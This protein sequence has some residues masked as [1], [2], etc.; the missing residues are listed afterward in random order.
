MRQVMRHLL[1]SIPL[2]VGLASGV[3]SDE[4]AYDARAAGRFVEQYCLDCHGADDP[5]AGL[6]LAGF[7]GGQSLTDGRPKWQKIVRR[8]RQHEMPPSDVEQPPLEER[9]AFAQWVAT[10]LHEQ[11]CGDG[12]WRGPAPIRRLNKSEYRATIRDLLGVHF[13]A[14]FALP[15]DGAGGEGFD[16]AAETLFLSPLHT[17]MYLEAAKQA[18]AYAANDNRAQQ[19]IFADQPRPELAVNDAARQVIERFALRA[20][21]RPPT[22]DEVD[23]LISL[24]TSAHAS[25]QSFED[26][27]LYALR[28]VLV[29]PN[30]LFRVEQRSK[31][32]QPEPLNDFE[33]ATRLSY[34]L[35]GSMP[36]DTLFDLAR[37]GKLRDE[38][39]LREQM[40][41]MAKDDKS[42]GFAESFMGQ[43]LG[44][45]RLGVSAKPN[46]EQFPE[47][48]YELED[49]MRQEPIRFFQEILAE[50]L[51]LLTLID[52]DFTYAN[53]AL[54]RLYE[55]EK[56]EGTELREWSI[57]LPL[58]EGS[59]RGG[60]LT[61]ASVLAT[62]S[63]PHRT[64]PVLRGKWVLETMLGAGPPPPPPEVPTLPEEPQE[65][66]VTLRARLE[67]HRADATCAACHRLMDPVGFCLENFDAIGRWRTE[68]SGHPI[69]ATGELPSGER[70]DGPDGLKK[71]LLER[72]DDFAR[73][74]TTKL[75]GYALGRG[76]VEKDYCE[77]D[78]IATALQD[79]DYKAQ[80]LVWGIITSPPFTMRGN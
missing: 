67:Q 44:V 61:M 68:D 60:V 76:L 6:T 8:V 22:T 11:I 71:L 3:Q 34:F 20:F 45:R 35:W 43:W 53:K 75:L 36:D 52:T 54:A 40:V 1:V 17:E 65:T 30:F 77:V 66:A 58:P 41:R 69:D 24:F 47:F 4:V 62:T 9:A 26:A 74:F 49:G 64:S 33:L 25:P 63:Y 5:Q 12:V 56:P 37:E 51:S 15:D 38:A 42:R 46:A 14:A 18:L 72:K 55:I 13:D 29:S 57:R 28:G 73:H 32:D 50:D 39:V 78:R 48:N 79:N 59:P 23:S 10:T 80:A 70:C 16:N 2:L 21:R 27:V 7:D 31:A 19:L